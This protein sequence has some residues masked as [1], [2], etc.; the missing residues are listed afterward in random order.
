M[1][2]SVGNYRLIERG[3]ALGRSGG[4]RE[5]GKRKMRVGGRLGAVKCIPTYIIIV[6][7]ELTNVWFRL[8]GSI[9]VCIK[10]VCAVGVCL[11]SVGCMCRG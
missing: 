9:M 10:C 5:K 8:A 1:C 2:V 7:A 3:R 4:E 11:F 6:H